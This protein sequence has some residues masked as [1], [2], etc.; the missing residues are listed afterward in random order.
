MIGLMIRDLMALRKRILLAGACCI[1]LTIG[2]RSIGE[3]ALVPAVL[4]AVYFV[5][6]SAF[7]YDDKYKVDGTFLSLPIR[8]RSL[9]LVRY[10]EVLVLTVSVVLIYILVTLLLNLCSPEMSPAGVLMPATAFLIAS[11]ISGLYMP[12]IYRLGYVKAK[13]YNMVILLAFSMIPAA[14]MMLGKPG[15]EMNMPLWRAT[16]SKGLIAALMFAAA[17][18]ILIV[19]CLLS[20]QLYRKRN[21]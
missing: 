17:I 20:I 11:L 1:V 3:F 13:I 6:V 5:L 15:G 7:E 18:V 4:I 21:F 16:T 19:S 8:R 12:I 9:V 14:V 10:L 2:L